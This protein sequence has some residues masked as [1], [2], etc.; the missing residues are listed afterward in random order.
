VE[1]FLLDLM[2]SEN[3]EE[4]VLTEELLDG[5]LSEV[6]RTVAL[7]VLLEISVHGFFVFHRVRPH[8]VAENTV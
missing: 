8:Q 7:W 5:L 3:T 1:A 4:L 2:A 6:V